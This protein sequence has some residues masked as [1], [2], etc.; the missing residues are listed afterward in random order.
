VSV[1]T[2]PEVEL[3]FWGT[4]GSRN[5]GASR[6]GRR[7]SC[8]SLRHGEDLYVCDA[9]TGLLELS[10]ALFGDP[11]LAGVA[12]VHVLVTHAHMD[13]WEG[14]K[15]AEWFWRKKNR[16]EV[17]LL[18][19]R[20]A[21]EAIRSAHAAP[22]F[23]PLEILALGTAERWSVVEL[24]AGQTVGL[25]GA[26]IETLP[27]NHFSGI[28]P[29]HRPLETL[30][31]RVAVAQGPTLAYLCDHQPTAA[32]LE[33]ELAAVAPAQVA[34]VDASYADVA[35]HAFG[36]GSMEY[37]AQLARQSPGC[38]VV[39]GHHGPTRTDETIEAAARKHGAGCPGLSIAVEGHQARWD[40][41]ARRFTPR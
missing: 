36:H 28:P 21:L 4:R 12:R 19:P 24:R 2:T 38:A 27:L 9:G 17:T 15:D 6:I 32:T 8:Y 16:L 37:A 30:G 34:I 3:R 41:A 39:A 31:Y 13:H 29:N 20:E 35:E 26:T 33:P 7:T 5:D 10:A 11:E 40:A 18:G 22:S 25:P 14:L 23:V 1:A